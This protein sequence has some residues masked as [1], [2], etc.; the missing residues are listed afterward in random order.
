MYDTTRPV[1]TQRR[2]DLL[3]PSTQRALG[4]NGIWEDKAIAA[5]SDSDLRRLAYI[6][7]VGRQD[8]RRLFPNR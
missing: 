8:I 3:L 4:R 5:L 6:G 1:A 2:F 7:P